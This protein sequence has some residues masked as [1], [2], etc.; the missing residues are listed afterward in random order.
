MS[1]VVNLADRREPVWYTVRIGHHWD[2]TLEVVIE[3]VSDDQRSRKS[4]I[5]AMQRVCGLQA[6]ADAMH[7]E[8]LQQV[9][10][11]MDASAE[12]DIQRLS[13]LAAI[14]AAYEDARFTTA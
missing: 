4:V 13:S 7:A 10:G 1:D 2:D 14:V 5:D 8:L 6:P 11:L 9:N 3:D 12:A